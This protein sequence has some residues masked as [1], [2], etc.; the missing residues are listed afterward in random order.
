MRPIRGDHRPRHLDVGHIRQFPL[1]RADDPPPY[2]TV[3]RM[4]D[5]VEKIDAARQRTKANIAF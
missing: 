3:G 4:L 2:Q 1:E 5:I